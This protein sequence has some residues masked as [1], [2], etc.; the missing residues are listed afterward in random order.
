[1][2]GQEVA[3]LYTRA[4]RRWIMAATSPRS[5]TRVRFPKYIL[6]AHNSDGFCNSYPASVGALLDNH[7]LRDSVRHPASRLALLF[8]GYRA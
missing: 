4:A 3:A 6:L 2:A 8:D 7:S 5:P 1:M